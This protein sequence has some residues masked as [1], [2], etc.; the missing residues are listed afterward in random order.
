MII[1]G[2]PPGMRESVILRDGAL[3]IVTYNSVDG[4]REHDWDGEPLDV[5]AS[6]FA[7]QHGSFSLCFDAAQN[8]VR[9]DDCPWTLVL[10]ADESCGW[11]GF[12]AEA[13]LDF[14]ARELA[15][16]SPSGALEPD[17][18]VT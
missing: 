1:T 7:G 8:Y 2:D 16:A 11:G 14:A 6:A 12:D 5:K 4:R 3:R 17:G 10:D 13:A 18:A 15:A 9:S